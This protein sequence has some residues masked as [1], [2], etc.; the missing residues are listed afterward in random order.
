MNLDELKDR[1][2]ENIKGKYP[3]IKLSFE[4][5]E[6]TEKL[7]A[8]GASTPVEV[9][10]AAKKMDDIENFASVLADK[11]KRIPYLRDVQI[12]QPLKFPTIN[13]RMDRQ[14]LTQMNLSMDNV[15][16]SLSDATASS[17]YTLKNLWLDDN[18]Q[19]TYNAQVQIPEYRMNSMEQ[20]AFHPTGAW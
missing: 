3:H 20:I 11:L 16:K 9:R 14:K 5:I 15:A 13:I 2:R 8:Q 17:R 18:K 7:M 12:S 10:V 4:P 6:L 1:I 19:Y